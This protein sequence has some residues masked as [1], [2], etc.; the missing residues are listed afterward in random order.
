[1]GALIADWKILFPARE[2]FCCAFEG[3]RAPRF[4]GESIDNIKELSLRS[5]ESKNIFHG[6][7][8]NKEAKH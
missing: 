1:M 6:M 7:I 3:R 2:F 4:E 5:V 8:H